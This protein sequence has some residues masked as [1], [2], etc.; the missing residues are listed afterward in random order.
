M[1]W[2]STSKEAE[3]SN[4]FIEVPKVI[5]K[6]KFSIGFAIF[7]IITMIWLATNPG[8]FIPYDW[9]IADFIAIL[10][11]STVCASHLLLPVV[12]NPALMTFTF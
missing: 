7:G 5:S 11:M 2:G 4:F 3:R 12:L 1:T 9:V 10:P 6:F 8:G